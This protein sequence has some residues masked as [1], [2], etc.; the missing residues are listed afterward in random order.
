M[1][2]EEELLSLAR[3]ISSLSYYK[4]LGLPHRYLPAAEV[5][6]AFH[7]FAQLFHPDL[8]Q[9]SDEAIQTAAKEVFKRA[10]EAYEALR[11]EPLQRHYVEKYLKQGQLRLPPSE[12]GR[13]PPEP[14]KPATPEPPK[15]KPKPQIQA[16]TWSDEMAT[17]DG[18]EVARRIE[19]MIGE[20]RY[21]AALQQM[22]LLT[23]IEGRTEAIKTKEA[24]L[25]RMVERGR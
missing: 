6:K 15:P 25:H 22:A 4:I 16:R 19:R 2:S 5:K 3:R 12:T 17:E 11:D 13:R 9:D 18:R 21:Q 1:S 7:A 23:S 14:P 24:Y 10:V 20:G 8:Y